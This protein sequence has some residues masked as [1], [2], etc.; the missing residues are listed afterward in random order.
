M[1][2][3][4]H[5]AGLRRRTFPSCYA[6]RVSKCDE[7]ENAGFADEERDGHLPEPPKNGIENSKIFYGLIILKKLPTRCSVFGVPKLAPFLIYLRRYI[8]TFVY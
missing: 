4:R 5:R 1:N 6:A 8:H 7:R 3:A 2:D